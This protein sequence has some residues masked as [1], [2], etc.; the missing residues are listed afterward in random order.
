MKN[1]DA[2]NFGR[3][4][5]DGEKTWNA[6]ACTNRLA[7]RIRREIDILK[8]TT[9]KETFDRLC[10]SC[11][12]EDKLWLDCYTKVTDLL[13][14]EHC[15][16]EVIDDMYAVYAIVKMLQNRFPAMLPH[17]H[18]VS[19]VC[20]DLGKTMGFTPHDVS[21]IG[22]LGVLH[23]VGKL[24]I[25]DAVFFK[26][27]PLTALEWEDI[28]RHPAIG[29]ELIKP[30]AGISELAEL[31]LAH[32]ERWD[33][34]G[35]PQG[36]KEEEIPLFSRILTL[37]DSLDAMINDRFYRKALS[38]PHTVTEIKRCSGNQFDPMVVEAFFDIIRENRHTLSFLLPLHDAL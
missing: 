15:T 38:P 26:Q 29:Y 32:H 30:I 34:Q 24:S 11:R 14:T 5:A 20:M 2:K 28:K 8:T 27:G 18:R 3:V 31:I 9:I 33:G 25:S 17:V 12:L 10:A 13:D 1:G 35:Y 23:D 21:V 6:D 7:A 36:L 37:A 22:A 19:A 4:V 16:T